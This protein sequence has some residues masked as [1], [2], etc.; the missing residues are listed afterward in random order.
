MGK[1]IVLLSDVGGT[2]VRFALYENGE[3][4]DIVKYKYTECPDIKSYDAFVELFLSRYPDKKITLAVVGTAGNI[5][6]NK[7]TSAS[8]LKVVPDMDVLKEKYALKEAKLVNDFILQGM[9][10]PELNADEYEQ[11]RM[12]EMPIIEPSV[13]GKKGIVGPGTGLGN[14]RIKRKKPD[15]RWDYDAAE[16]G[17]STVPDFFK[18]QE[19]YQIQEGLEKK[20]GGALTIE[21][22]VSGR[23]LEG[24]YDTLL[25]IYKHPKP[26]EG[27]SAQYVTQKYKEE[28]NKQADCPPSGQIENKDSLATKA[29]MYFYTFLALHT[30]NMIV[31]NL[32]TE[33]YFVGS[34]LND[35]VIREDL[36]SKNSVFLDVLYNKTPRVMND[37][38]RKAAIYLVTTNDIAFKG[39]KLLADQGIAKVTAREEREVADK[40]A[41]ENKK[42]LMALT[43]LAVAAEQNPEL[44]RDIIMFARGLVTHPI[45]AGVPQ[46]EKN[47]LHSG[48]NVIPMAKKR[49]DFT[50]VVHTIDFRQHS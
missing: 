13:V 34:L 27:F 25:D 14:C 11:V 5:V 17:Q 9:A 26:T 31:S 4:Q 15:A 47:T 40:K 28:K 16:A 24:I 46:G 50:Q 42:L 19:Y 29:H 44:E 3:V 43:S 38:V 7:V 18:T 12:D 8:N 2:N 48:N 36:T 23:A 10:I 6:G 30:Y 20:S 1:E 32:L 45:S 37:Y 33:V 39:L 22:F 21:K 35:S 49:L 41:K